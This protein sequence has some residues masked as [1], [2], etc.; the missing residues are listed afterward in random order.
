MPLAD[1][2]LAVGQLKLKG[3]IA[4]STLQGPD[5]AAIHAGRINSVE[6]WPWQEGPD[7][8]IYNSQ[9]NA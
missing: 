9:D 1:D 2:S 3:V 7:S 6:Y 5:L 4:F 8:V